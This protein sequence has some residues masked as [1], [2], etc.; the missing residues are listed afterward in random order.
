MM[1]PAEFTPL[2]ESEYLHDEV[3]ALRAIYG[4]ANISFRPA[5]STT[6]SS[7]SI[8]LHALLESQPHPAGSTVTLSA[9]LPSTYPLSSRPKNPKLRSDKIAAATCDILLDRML[10][11]QT[12]AE[13]EVC[14]FE[15]CEAMLGV[16][17]DFAAEAGNGQQGETAR[18][19]GKDTMRGHE[20]VANNNFVLF[21]GEPLTDRKSVFQ[22]HLAKITCQ[23]EVDDVLRQL[24]QTSRKLA[25]ATHNSCAYRVRVADKMAQD[26]DDDGEKGAG[27][28]ILFVL[29][30]M[31]VM[32]CVVVVSRWFGG[33]LLGPT[34]FRHICKV[35]RDL[36][37]EHRGEFPES[38]G[39]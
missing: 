35:S 34:R 4:E 23:E 39:T 30:Q 1:P 12:A 2:Q 26:V 18:S 11:R 3:E 14:L 36:I 7:I 10:Q 17:S 8:S 19:S 21:H 16:L 5:S 22:A 13:G 37:E 38:D 29:Q 6:M 25:T 20:A 28:C 32:N 15:Y 31:G 24:K 9:L 27:K 33:V